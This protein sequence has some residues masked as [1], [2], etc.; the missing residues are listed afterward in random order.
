MAELRAASLV[1]SSGSAGRRAPYHN[2]IR[3]ALVA[4]LR[5][6]APSGSTGGWR[7]RFSRRASTTPR[8]CSSIAGGAGDRAAAAKYA[9]LAA[10]EAASALAFDRA[11]LFY[12]HALTLAPRAAAHLEWK[13]ARGAALANA[14]RPAEAGGKRTS[15]RPP[16]RH[17]SSDWS[18]NAE[19]P[20]SS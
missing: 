2:R 16:L 17:E 15:T 10:R 5:T 7:R 3:Q 4:A 19:P 11:A 1:R 6:S 18:S 12:S 14:G 20:S 13:E 8:R 9:D